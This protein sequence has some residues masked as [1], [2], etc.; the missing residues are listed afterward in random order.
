MHGV[1]VPTRPVEAFV[2]L[3]VS[4]ASPDAEP[5]PGAEAIDQ[6]AH[7]LQCAHELALLRPEDEELQIAGLLH[8]IGHHLVPGDDAGHGVH[9][10]EFVRPVVGDRIADLI[11]LHVPAKRYL[12]STEADYAGTLS[13]TSVRTLER[14]GGAMTP[15]EIAAFEER[16]HWEDAL[17][18]RRA[19]EAAKVP[20]RAVP[21]LKAWIPVLERVVAAHDASA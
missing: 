6:L 1:P 9:A 5:R 10:G 21:G 11:E 18:L 14:Q 15:A 2:L 16:A 20:G 13:G 17:V 3:L 19:D 8:D 4:G 12:V 7:A